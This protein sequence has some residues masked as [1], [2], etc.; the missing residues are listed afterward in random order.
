MQRSF[1]RSPTSKWMEGSG[2]YADIVITSRIRLA[3]NIREVPFPHVLDAE[4][5]KRVV[6]QVAQVLA[7]EQ[8]TSAVGKMDVVVLNE[9]NPLERRILVEKHLISPQHAQANGYAAVALNRDESLSIM[10]N[11]EDHLRIQC[12]LPALQLHETWRIADGIDDV[13]EQGLDYAFAE[14]AGYLTACPTNVGTG[15]RASVMM[16]LPGLVLT[17]QAGRVLSALPQVGLVVRGIYGE[18]TEAHGNLFQI[19]NQITLGRTEDEVIKSLSSVVKQIIEQE[20]SAREALF[21]ETGEKLADKLS[22]AYGILSHARVISSEEALSLLSDLRLGIDLK[23][24]KDIDARVF[25]ELMVLI[26]PACLQ[27]AA[28][29]EMSSFERDVQRADLIR[30]RLKANR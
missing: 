5:Q 24:I 28:G 29:K 30:D 22:R 26:Q 2:P 15:L 14:Q 11:E 17:R 4:G 9:L 13:L 18:G 1:K 8:V 27:R 19:S 7:T 25:N 6:M 16:H 12:L 23:I 21:K 10:I 3:R 20:R